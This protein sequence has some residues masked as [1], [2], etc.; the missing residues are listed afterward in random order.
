MKILNNTLEFLNYRK[1]INDSTIGFVPTMGGLHEGHLSLI[2]KSIMENSHTVMSIFLNPTQFN[3][4]EDFEKYPSS[5]DDDLNQLKQFDNL[6][7]FLPTENSIYPRGYNF[8]IT[9]SEFS[10]K[11]CGAY[12]PGHFDGVLT[13][14]MKLLNIVRPNKIYLG[15]K[16][17]QQL[18]LITQMIEDFFMQIQVVPCPVVRDIDGLALSTRNKRLNSN[19][20]KLAV[21][22][23]KILQTK[24]APIKTRLELE[25]LGLTVD[26]VEEY[27]SRLLAAVQIGPVRLIDNVEK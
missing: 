16:D 8:K 19:D 14:V 17:F 2:K 21:E 4:R 7:V 10:K 5:I 11:L 6:S 18:E 13:V 23:A 15:E 24:Q 3:N 12:R 22:F 26:Y 20:R 27:N 9:E 25:K 1:L